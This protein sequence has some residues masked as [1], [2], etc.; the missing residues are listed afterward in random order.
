MSKIKLVVS[1]LHLGVGKYLAGGEI[2]AL[3]EFY[4]DDRFSEFLSYYTS[5]DYADVEVELILNGD[6]LNFLQV[7]FRGHH[8]SVITESISLEKLKNI[9]A[10]H[11]VFFQ[12]LRKFAAD[13]KHT[14]TYVVGNHDQCMMWPA[15]RAYF[16]ESVGAAVRFKNIVYFFDGVHVEHGHMHEAANRIDPKK[17]FIKKDVP[18]PILN[19]PLGSHFFIDFVLR[20]KLENPYIDKVRPF[21]NFIRW[22]LFFDTKFALKTVV[23]LLSYFAARITGWRSP[24]KRWSLRRVLKIFA[25][26]AVFPDLGVSARRHFRGRSCPYGRFWPLTRLSV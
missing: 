4:Y 14:V 9:V 16:C 3:E 12:A 24:K 15:T 19:L 10:G 13:L 22:G 21:R 2:N 11:P 6:I 23:R 20:V 25:E 5:G 17:F 8:L 1:D 7:D 18:E 26:G